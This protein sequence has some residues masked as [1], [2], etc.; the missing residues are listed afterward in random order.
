MEQ[1]TEDVVGESL[2]LGEEVE[3]IQT[4]MQQTTIEDHDDI[5]DIPSMDSD[6]KYAY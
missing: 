4:A 3:W 6:E 2:G 5:P 1:I